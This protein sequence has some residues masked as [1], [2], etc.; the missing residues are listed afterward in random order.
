MS[1]TKKILTTE[2]LADQVLALRERL[3][4]ALQKQP[5]PSTRLERLAAAALTGICSSQKHAGWS[6]SEKAD[7]AISVAMHTAEMLRR[8]EEAYENRHALRARG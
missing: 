2:E 5:K 8:E 3:E 7:E 1:E 4:A 6:E